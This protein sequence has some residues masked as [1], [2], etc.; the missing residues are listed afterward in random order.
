ME[1]RWP[2]ALW[3]VRHGESA[4]NVARDAAYAAGLSVIDITER[5]VDVPLSAA[6]EAQS[7]ALGGWFARMPPGARPNV[8]L[9]SPYLRA[10]HTASIIESVGGVA[11]GAM[12]IADERLREKEFG[13]LDRLTK[14][15]VEQRFPEQAEARA[16]VGKFYFRPPGGESWCDVILRLRSVFDTISLHHSGPGKRVLIVAHQVI[17]LCCRYLLEGLDEGQILAIDRERD[18]ANC[19]VTW[20]SINQVLDEGG[21]LQLRMHAF[22][23]PL[24]EAGAPVTT[25]PDTPTGAK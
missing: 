14:L 3:I 13:I 12:T 1:Q 5:D 7:E 8:V 15:G 20:Y 11:P 24:Q 17:V 16:R 18:I 23:A 25:K 9:V 4:G 21:A 2:D 10:R 22:V 6:G 19:G